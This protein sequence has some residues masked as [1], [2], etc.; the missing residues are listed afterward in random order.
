MHPQTSNL[1]PQ[2]SNLAPQ[3]PAPEPFAFNQG[4]SSV[5]V[6]LLHGWTGSPP[7]MQPLGAYLAAQGWTVHGPLLPGHG[8]QPEDMLR[9]TERDWIAAA[10][11]AY[12]ALA[13]ECETVFA[14]GLSMGGLL[15]LDL[16][17]TLSRPPT[18]I[19]SMSAPIF[20][21]DWRRYLAP[22]AP[23][24]T[25]FQPWSHKEATRHD[26]DPTTATR[27]WD[28]RRYPTISGQHILRLMNRVRA[29]LP[30]V[31]APLLV[32]QG[33]QDHTVVPAS[34]QYIYDHVASPD[35][36]LVW[37]ERSAHCITVDAERTAVWS[38]TAAW[39][40]AHLSSAQRAASD[41]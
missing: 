34:A 31:R 12:A 20:I 22:A 8:T 28:Y 3:P 4:R 29:R 26:V 10:A 32:M 14:G 36:T 6:L 2:T 5:G 1:K 17:A 27:L 23:L 33:R 18:G 37:W 35:K 40:A 7:E 16:G 41:Q 21:T 9:V 24:L 15:A 30:Q 38:R 11:A 39:I 19:I 25:R 13:A